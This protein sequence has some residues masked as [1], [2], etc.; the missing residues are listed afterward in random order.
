VSVNHVDVR[1]IRTSPIPAAAAKASEPTS[2][3]YRLRITEL[4]RELGANFGELI[5]FFNAKGFP[6]PQV[7][8]GLLC[9]DAAI[10]E[11]GGEPQSR[12]TSQ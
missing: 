2:R 12:G 10:T 4:K 5:P 11:F 1:S 9:V 7:H 8:R 6:F 3:A